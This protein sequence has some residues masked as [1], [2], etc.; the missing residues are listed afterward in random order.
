MSLHWSCKK[1]GKHLGG[2]W[3]NENA[4]KEENEKLFD[5]FFSATASSVCEDYDKCSW[6][7]KTKNW[8]ER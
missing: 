3:P 2:I 4:T 1:C 8:T 6:K 5:G 7:D